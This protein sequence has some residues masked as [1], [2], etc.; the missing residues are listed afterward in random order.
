MGLE[1]PYASH[2]KDHVEFKELVS[3]VLA[4]DYIGAL[5]ASILFPILFVPRLGLIRTSLVFGMLNA[6]VALWGTWLLR[7]LIKGRIDGLRIKAVIV[8]ALLLFGL[9]KA[10]TITSLA[11]DEM[12]ATRSFIR[13]TLPISAS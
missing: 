5:L 10:N 3:R 2:L 9:V 8:L 11:E 7:P 1:I 4:F 12:F 6:G 13:R